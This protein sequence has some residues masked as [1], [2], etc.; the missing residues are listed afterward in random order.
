M[1]RLVDWKIHSHLKDWV[2]IEEAM[3]GGSLASLPWITHNTTAPE[4]KDNILIIATLKTLNTL[5]KV[6]KWSSNPGPLTPI[7]GNPKFPPGNTKPVQKDIKTA[8]SRL[9]GDFFDKGLFKDHASLNSNTEMPPIPWWTY[10]QIRHFLSDKSSMTSYARDLTE[11]EKLLLS[12]SP[13]RHLISQIYKLLSI[14]QD[15]IPDPGW[16]TWGKEIP[17]LETPGNWEYISLM[18]HKGSRNVSIQE[19]GYKIQSR[20]YRTPV[21]LHKLFPSSGN[22]MD[23][24]IVVKE[25]YK[26]E[27]EEYGVMEE[28]YKDYKHRSHMSDNPNSCPECGK[29]FTWKSQLVIHQR[30]HTGEKPYLCPECGKCFTQKSALVIHQRCHTGE[31][32]YS[33]PDCGK[34]FSRMHHLKIH[35][36]FHMAEK[37]YSCPECRK[38]FTQKSHL[39]IHQKSHTGEKPYS[40]PECGKCF[41]R[42]DHLKRHQ[43]FHMTEKPYSCPECRKCFVLKSHLVTHQ[44]THTGEKPYACPECGKCFT[45]KSLLV[46]H[47]RSHTGEKPY[48]C[49]ECGKCYSH[50]SQLKAHQR[51]HLT[52]KP[53]SCPECRKCFLQ[54]S[55]LVI[56]Q[57]SH[58]GEKP[59]SCPD[60]GK[61]FSHVS[62]LKTHQRSHMREKP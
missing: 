36:K 17:R 11:F 2:K 14:A 43:K 35:Q 22:N 51:F 53:Y 26:D 45:R 23:Y 29:C 61:C 10:L 56:H 49:P 62:N 58:T 8:G 1:A 27:D 7:I 47:Q 52:E 34:C 59:Y 16:E 28:F 32:P 48:L 54:K 41:A 31:K 37:P 18:N 24:N 57:R 20:W 55:Q 6:I 33:C 42:M 13:K 50:P 40:C 39:V 15:K 46:I 5:N 44:R 30:S 38:C 25:E 12:K 3:C 21:V 19:T 9:A 60:C 4:L